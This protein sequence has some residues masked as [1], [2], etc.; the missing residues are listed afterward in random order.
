LKDT[1]RQVIVRGAGTSKG[2]HDAAAV[3]ILEAHTPPPDAPADGP[4]QHVHGIAR[5]VEAGETTLLDLTVRH[6]SLLPGASAYGVYVAKT[7]DISDGAASTGGVLRMLGQVEVGEKDGYGDL[8]TEVDRLHL[9]Q[10]IGRA[11]VIAP[12]LDGGHPDSTEPKMG[13]G[14]LAGVIARSAGLWGTS[15][16][17]DKTVCSCSG[18]TMWE[19]QRCASCR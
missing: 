1:G 13:A 4:S 8:F 14:L 18:Q 16:A 17:N 2:D 3:C 12:L 7:G 15:S 9:W 19:E 6:R 11:M 5:L 10:I